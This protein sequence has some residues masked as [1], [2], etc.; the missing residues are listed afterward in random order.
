MAEHLP[1]DY[2]A[3][4]RS[5]LKSG[6]YLYSY[7]IL[8]QAQLAGGQI[9]RELQYL[10]I[11]ALA[12]AGST[13]HALEQYRKLDLQADELNEDWLALEGRLLKDLAIQNLP[14][15]QAL[16]LSS[17]AAYRHSHE[18]TGGYFSGINAATMFALGGEREHSRTLAREVMSMV[19]AISPRDDRD[20]FYL[21]ATE[22]EAALL[23]ADFKRCEECLR[24][25]DRLLPDDL[26][27]RSR[28]RSQLKLL[29][30]QLGIDGKPY[31][32]LRMP[33]V[34]YVEPDTHGTQ[35]PPRG[36]LL[37]QVD[38]TAPLM[39][40]AL[41]EPAQLVEAEHCLEHGARLYAIIP[42]ARAD[43]I[44]R[45]HR[46]YGGAWAGR[47]ARCLEQAHEVSV[48]RGFLDG[49]T[50]FCLSYIADMSLGLSRLT[51]KRLGGEWTAVKSS[52][53][54]LLASADFG[55]E[56]EA[57]SPG[58]HRSLA[59]LALPPNRRYVG[60]IFADFLG[61]QRLGDA[62]LPRFSSD[63]MGAAA[64]LL[65]RHRERILFRHTWGDA[66]HIVTDDAQTAAEIV[67][68][69]NDFI[70]AP[71]R[72]SGGQLAELEIRLAAHYAPV[73]VGHDP[74]EETL[75][76]YGTQLSCTARIEPVTPPGMVYVTEA[77]A[78]RLA[79]EAPQHFALD[80][81]GEVE[82]AKRYGKYRL[83]SLRKKRRAPIKN[84]GES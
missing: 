5:A 48:A 58:Q 1:E 82:L 52:D 29:C 25:A 3:R 68:E 31:R 14:H 40:M 56:G 15:S 61:F 60:L 7:D 10:M 32:L 75:T 69:L 28:T 33:P 73:F 66:I 83:F 71:L 34:V 77:F 44:G 11:L 24:A 36:A 41:L 79:L 9:T 46:S 21:L 64:K 30:R 63:V 59:P 4:A 6:N 76:Y 57:Q 78:A 39:F 55:L 72:S 23:L 19:G 16:F 80:Y 2:A 12:N 22:A 74:I 54:K 37:S 84:E 50:D 45:W 70:A 26:N 53:G 51:A 43:E 49:E 42:G 67:T 38:N 18:R 35:R 81:A 62:E 13:R 65:A 8:A 20:H 47:L 27:S 17:A